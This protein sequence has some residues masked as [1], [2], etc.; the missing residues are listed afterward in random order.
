LIATAQSPAFIHNDSLSF[1]VLRKSGELLDNG[2]YK[3]ISYSIRV[4]ISKEQREIC[5]QISND[6]WLGLLQD[7]KTDWAANLILYDL[8]EKDALTYLNTYKS[9]SVWIKLGQRDADIKY[10]KERLI[11][12]K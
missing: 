9:R 11:R 7:E 10:W 4:K 3:P 8:F 5:K 12:R 1:V 2:G 6:Q